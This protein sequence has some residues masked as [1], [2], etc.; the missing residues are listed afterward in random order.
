MSICILQVRLIRAGAAGRVQSCAPGRA[1]PRVRRRVRQSRGR[2]VASAHRRRKGTH[3]RMQSARVGINTRARTRA[4]W[5]LKRKKRQ[6][7]AERCAHASSI[8]TY[9]VTG[10]L[11]R[12]LPPNMKYFGICAL[13]LS[14]YTCLY[15]PQFD[16]CVGIPS[17][18]VACHGP[19]RAILLG[20]LL[21][22]LRARVFPRSN[23][24]RGRQGAGAHLPT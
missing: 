21:Q 3:T 1:R 2:Q 20:R 4:R 16:W 23:Y 18:A 8:N 24:E 9:F 12:P 19:N 22:G 14:L 15:L 13:T 5:P 11:S 7:H 10:F 6:Q 17:G